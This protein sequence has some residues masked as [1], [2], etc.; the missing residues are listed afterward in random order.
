MFLQTALKNGGPVG[1]LLG[2][3]IIGTV[4]YSLC[5]SVGEMIAFL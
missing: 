2:Y 3:F 1:A 4:V 5:V